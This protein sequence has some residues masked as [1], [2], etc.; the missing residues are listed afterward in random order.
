MMAHHL[1]LLVHV[2]AHWIQRPPIHRQVL[3]T[4]GCKAKR[5]DAT[6]SQ[7]MMKGIIPGRSR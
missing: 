7:Q 2:F 5:I 1:H 3:L 6:S 4:R